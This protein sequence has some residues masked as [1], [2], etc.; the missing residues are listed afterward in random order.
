MTLKNCFYL[1]LHCSVAFVVC[2]MQFPYET[3][4]SYAVQSIHVRVRECKSDAYYIYIY[5]G[6]LATCAA[7]P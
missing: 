7:V 5:R 1:W 2:S 3:Q 6:Q 4:G